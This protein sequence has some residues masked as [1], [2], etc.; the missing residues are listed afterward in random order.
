[1]LTFSPYN[2]SVD[3]LFPSL[4]WKKLEAQRKIETASMVFKSLKGLAR[5]FLNSLFSYR[6]EVSSYF[7]SD[8]KGNLPLPLP[9]TN[10]VIVSATEVPCCGKV[11]LLSCGKRKLFPLLNTAAVISFEICR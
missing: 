6:N 7:L 1:M 2:A 11:Y 10:Y 9:R 4:A 8:C 3:N 5:Q